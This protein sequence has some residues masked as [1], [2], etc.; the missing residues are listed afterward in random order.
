MYISIHGS[1]NG[2]QFHGFTLRVY[3][4]IYIYTHA[5]IYIYIKKKGQQGKG[6]SV[7]YCLGVRERERDFF[8][9]VRRKGGLK[10][11]EWTRAGSTLE[12]RVGKEKYR[13]KDEE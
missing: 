7:V 9:K 2:S 6:S 10:I 12:K 13:R 11:W 5:H 4:N 1:N 8:G 3:I